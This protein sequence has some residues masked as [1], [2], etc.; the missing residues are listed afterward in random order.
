MLGSPVGMTE[1]KIVQYLNEA[2]A[3][4]VG[5]IRV[6]QSQIAVTPRGSYRSAL[7]RHLS[8]TRDHAARVERRLDELGAGKAIVHTAIGA[9][10]TALAQGLAIGKFPLDLLR[11]H[12]G[13]EKVLKNAK[14]AAATEA[15]EIATYTA[16]ERLARALGDDTTARMA[17]S[18]R[19]DEERM[20]AAIVDV[21]PALTDAVLGGRYRVATTGA[22]ETVRRTAGRGRTAAK[23]TAT[24]AKRTAR[25][26][27]GAARA[28]GAAQGAVASADDLPIARY[29]TLNAQEIVERLPE[30]S[31]TD[32]AKVE[33]YERRHDNRTT[34][35]D[36]IA[37]LRSTEPWPGYD[38]QTADEVA[39]VLRSA[40]DDDERRRAARDYERAHKN[41][42][43]V[44]ELV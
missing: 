17:A 34:V 12:G 36:R 16:L 43:T 33:A 26:A 3:T 39:S 21:I 20:L 38:D 31:Q 15:L 7:E 22:G 44:L 40:G 2:R 10:E 19:E 27:P 25:R 1:N 9:A 5:L 24:R 37:A 35:T 28:A 6:L 13:A 18:I 29:D 42:A 32:L 23:K 30:L 41:R 14:D 8:E 4:E 11:G